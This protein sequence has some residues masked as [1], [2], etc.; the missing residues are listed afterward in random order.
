MMMRDGFKAK[1]GDLWPDI[2]G[3]AKILTLFKN[4]IAEFEEKL[5]TFPR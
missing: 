3:A 2:D 5:H 4:A 1:A